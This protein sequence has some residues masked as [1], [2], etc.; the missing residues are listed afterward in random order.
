MTAIA[1]K[2]NGAA[3]EL[4]LD[5]GGTALH[6]APGW[7]EHRGPLGPQAAFQVFRHA[8]GVVLVDLFNT[9]RDG[10]SVTLE[11]PSLNFL[12]TL[13]PGA[14]SAFEF[15]PPELAKTALMTPPVEHDVLPSGAVLPDLV[16]V[17]E[18]GSPRNATIPRYAAAFDEAFIGHAIGALRYSGFQ[19]RRRFQRAGPD[20]R[21]T[22]GWYTENDPEG[23]APSAKYW[24][25]EPFIVNS[26]VYG[27]K[28]VTIETWK[29]T[30]LE[31]G[32]LVTIFKHL[33]DPRSFD[34]ARRLLESFLQWDWYCGTMTHAKVLYDE[35]TRI[36]GRCL[37]AIG[38]GLQLAQLAGDAELEARM[39][40]HG[41]FHVARILALWGSRVFPSASA[42]DSRHIA[43]AKWDNT[44]MIGLLGWGASIAMLRGLDK[45]RVIAERCA[46][47]LDERL[48][49]PKSDTFFQDI[50]IEPSEAAPTLYGQPGK[51]K[52]DGTLRWCA[53]VYFALERTNSPT[54][55][56]ILEGAA[57]IGQPIDNPVPSTS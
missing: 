36:K 27:P 39:R 28:P 19:L 3:A 44:W 31:V 41:E 37:E 6:H 52:F 24:P 25:R 48:W 57:A 9:R 32:E 54:C 15:V 35:N 23:G 7:L 53:P 16:Q 38:R 2:V 4:S 50:P 12:L 33:R 20:G 10:G 21:F 40:E 56:R 42:P 11:V 55:Q 46:D 34:Q 14:G 30:H 29:A 1:V 5:A 43:K 49:D 22:I 45:A 51:P 18:T 17:G 26:K 13:W 8:S 47:V